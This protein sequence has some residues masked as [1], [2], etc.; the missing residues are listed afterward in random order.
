MTKSNYIDKC[1]ITGE[2]VS[3]I[4]KLGMHPYADTFIK[5]DQKNLSEPVFPL[6][7]AMNPNSGQ[8]QL[9]YIS[10]DTDRYNLYDYSYTSA[11]S[12]FSR[13]HWDDYFKTIKDRYTIKD[14]NVLEIGSNDGYLTEKFIK[15]S[16]NVLGID[17]STAMCEVANKKGV[18]TIAEIFTHKLATK[19]VDTFDIIIANN[20][21]NHANDPVD[22]AKG[23]VHL[24]SDHGVF[25]FE[26]PYWGSTIQSGKFDQ[27]YHEHVSYFTLKS[28]KSLMS[29]VGLEVVDCE[30]VDYHGGSIR[31]YAKK[32]GTSEVSERVAEFQVKENDLNLFDMR[33]YVKFQEHIIESRNTFLK[34][35]YKLKSEGAVIIGVGAAAK[36]NT[37]LNFYNLDSSVLDYVTDSSEFKQGKY[38]PLTRIKIV[39]DDIFAAYEEVYALILSWNIS[40]QLIAN[41]SKI[42]PK[43]KFITPLI[44]F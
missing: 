39:P 34:E 30:L 32:I 15:D 40:N 28:G 26:L 20:V 13:K 8:I 36:A 25:V 33:T 43:I 21:F 6:E 41:L 2:S 9:R 5:E 24:L 22:F 14:A 44:S 23:V 1:L 19:L 3:T 12:A 18:N 29:K 38:T 4:I 37:L 11:N 42:N 16:K 27:I 31:V 17:S 35:L 7:V 10:N